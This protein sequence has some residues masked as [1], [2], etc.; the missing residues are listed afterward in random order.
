[1]LLKHFSQ[2]MSEDD[3]REAIL[4]LTCLVRPVRERA[5][6]LLQTRF[7]EIA[8]KLARKP[9]PPEDRGIGDTKHAP[10]GSPGTHTMPHGDGSGQTQARERGGKGGGGGVGGAGN[11]DG[12][13]NPAS[14]VEL[15]R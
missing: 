7:K 3:R 14:R 15:R 10:G 4:Q 12:A 9:S 11:D 1:M 5:A 13:V 2:A 6:R 8:A